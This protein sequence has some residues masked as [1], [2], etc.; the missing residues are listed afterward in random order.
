M[1]WSIQ[2]LIEDALTSSTR[3]TN[4][5]REGKYEVA[6]YHYK[7][8]ATFLELAASGS[9]DAASSDSWKKKAAEYKN[10][11][12]V[13]EQTGEYFILSEFLWVD[14]IYQMYEHRYAKISM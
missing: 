11:A 12:E 14:K 6:A 4:F 1:S 10:R 13:L 9:E 5:D 7:E 8:A 2:G 3:A